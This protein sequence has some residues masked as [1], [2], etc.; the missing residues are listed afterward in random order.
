MAD[1]DQ[2]QAT[3]KCECVSAVPNLS[4]PQLQSLR[5]AVV[6]ELEARE[7]FN[8]LASN[9]LLLGLA[10][11][12]RVTKRVKPKADW[13]DVDA[14]YEIVK[15]L[16]PE[17]SRAAIQAFTMLWKRG[18]TYQPFY[19]EFARIYLERHGVIRNVFAYFSPGSAGFESMKASVSA[20]RNEEDHN[21]LKRIEKQW[22]LDLAR[23][24]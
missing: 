15:P 18:V 7:R 3:T 13:L 19:P 17:K 14:I 4:T 11:A 21:E 10:D 2:P 12:M 1:K 8:R 16:G 5:D 24:S 22:A 23:G 20:R 9:S 6:K